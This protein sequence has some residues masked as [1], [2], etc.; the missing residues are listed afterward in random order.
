LIEAKVLFGDAIR[1]WKL[2]REKAKFVQQIAIE[3]DFR[4]VWWSFANLE[5]RAVLLFKKR[6]SN[7]SIDI[8]A[9]TD[10]VW[11]RFILR[12]LPFVP[13]HSRFS[14]A[15]NGWRKRLDEKRLV[16]AAK[17][18]TAVSEIDRQY[19]SKISKSDN[20]IMIVRNA[21]TIED[22]ETI[23]QSASPDNYSS[24]RGVLLM[25]S[26]G[27]KNSPMDLGAKWFIDT[28]WPKIKKVVKDSELHIVGIGSQKFLKSDAIRGIVVH[29]SVDSILQFVTICKVSIVPLFFESGTR[30]LDC[31]D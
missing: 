5:S 7:T 11:S 4:L 23:S 29:G 30:F 31:N 17:I 3:N 25:G 22:Y 10:S 15:W 9:D 16:R 19:Y 14:T 21:I 27:R 2:N 26:F 1:A 8:V 6:V 13:L 24:G 18:L 12:S 28:T 20:K